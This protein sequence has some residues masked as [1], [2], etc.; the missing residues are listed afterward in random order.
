MKKTYDDEI[1]KVWEHIL[2]LIEK[3]VG[4]YGLNLGCKGAGALNVIAELV[5]CPMIFLTVRPPYIT[6]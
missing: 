3:K 6:N 1:K 4:D 2:R 5:L